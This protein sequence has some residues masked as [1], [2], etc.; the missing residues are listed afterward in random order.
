MKQP[1]HDTTCLDM[2]V[3]AEIKTNRGN[4]QWYI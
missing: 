1:E 3:T 4:V 2:D